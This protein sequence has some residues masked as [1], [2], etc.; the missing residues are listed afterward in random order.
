MAQIQV[1]GPSETPEVGSSKLQ[2]CVKCNGK[3]KGQETQE[4]LGLDLMECQWVIVEEAAR[5]EL[6]QEMLDHEIDALYAMLDD[7]SNIAP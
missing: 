1:I 7:E 3:G 6:Q 5:K 2:G 4:Q